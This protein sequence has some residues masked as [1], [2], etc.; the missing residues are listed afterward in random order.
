[1]H[2]TNAAIGLAAFLS[3]I[4]GPK[5]AILG[6]AGE[7]IHPGI[8]LLMAAPG[9]PQWRRL[10]ELLS[11]P[12]RCCQRMFREVS[13]E[14]S[15]ERLDALQF[16]WASEGRTNE[17]VERLKAGPFGEQS[18]APSHVRAD[19]P[20]TALRQPTFVLQ[21]PEAETFHKALAETL[22]CSPLLLYPEAKA[23]FSTH[24]S[25]G[26]KRR[27]KE[28]GHPQAPLAQLVAAALGG[29]DRLFE[30]AHAKAGPGSIDTV[31]AHLVG[32]CSRM[33]LQEALAQGEQT[34]S[35]G[36]IL[37]HCLLLSAS[38]DETPQC[39]TSLENVRYGYSLYY[40]AIKSVLHTRRSGGGV[41]FSPNAQQH[42]ALHNLTLEL[43]EWVNRLPNALRPFFGHVLTLH[44]R[45]LWA[46]LMM[47]FRE[48]GEEW[49]IPFTI[50]TTRA[51]IEK[52]KALLEEIFT[53]AE[54]AAFARAQ[55]VMLHKLAA[56]PLLLR[57]LLRS[58]SRQRR[59]LHEPVL[60]TLLAE[61]LVLRHGD[62]L[63]ELSPNGRKR[64]ELLQR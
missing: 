59:D 24:Q 63:L 29:E 17:V 25:S 20:F 22:D 58:Y 41:V 19:R 18:G 64:I 28:A 12:I 26:I 36:R 7:Y 32:T 8:N 27:G 49:L 13:W 39:K 48:E 5:A 42:T 23:I 50:Q 14:T 52:E 6:P 54:Q 1:M 57:E 10:E 38:A 16:S 4:A 61:E 51:V 56:R 34:G 62:G 35:L 33:Q 30:K 47:V 40:D 3:G 60:E 15:S 9:S 46:F 53:G 44:Y 31:R 55:L 43:C 2:F 45:L 21:S 11:E 37:E